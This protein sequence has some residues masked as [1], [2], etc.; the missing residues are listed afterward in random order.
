MRHK[1]VTPSLNSFAQMSIRNRNPARNH[2]H[3][4]HAVDPSNGHDYEYDYDHDYDSN[5]F[6]N[7]MTTRGSTVSP[8]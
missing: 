4:L 2:I 1:R 3:Q 5:L 7:G 6:G 8:A